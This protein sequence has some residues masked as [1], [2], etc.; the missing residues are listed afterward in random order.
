MK[1][2]LLTSLFILVTSITF[3]QKLERFQDEYTKKWGFKNEAGKIIIEPKYDAAYYNTNS[4]NT[5]YIKINGKF[6]FINSQGVEFI[7]PIYDSIAYGHFSYSEKIAMVK[8]N[9]K[10]GGIDTLG[11][12]RIPFIYD[13]S[14][15]PFAIYEGNHRSIHSKYIT[16]YIPVKLNNKWGFIDANGNEVISFKYDGFYEGYSEYP[17]FFVNEN[18][19]L[20]I[21][22]DKGNEVYPF[23]ID[24]VIES[25]DLKG[26]TEF[27]LVLI[28]GKKKKIILD[29]NTKKFIK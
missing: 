2:T 18:G 17:F 5:A 27:Y 19:K 23:T 4:S 25:G 26:F 11:K 10:W 24:K 14:S 28:D 6:G 9:G 16:S 8:L 13:D 22:D 3:S 15:H 21:I 20:G 12:E 7:E 1:T 29:R